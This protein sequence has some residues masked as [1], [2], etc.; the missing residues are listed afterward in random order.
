MHLQRLTR[1][2]CV[3]L[4]L[5]GV[6]SAAF[7]Q[8][9]TSPGI[10]PESPQSNSPPPSLGSVTR[11]NSQPLD[12]SAGQYWATYDLKPYTQNLPAQSAPE[13]AIVDW[14]IRE[15]GTDIWFHQPM[16]IMSAS[17][18]KLM[19]Y[20][21]EGVH[22]IVK[23]VYERFVNGNTDPQQFS[24]RLMMVGSSNWRT[25]TLAWMKSVDI[26]SP[27]VQG[28]LLSKEQAA[29]LAST[30]HNRSDFRELQMPQFVGMNGQMQTIDNQRSIAYVCGYDRIEQPYPSYV[31]ISDSISE[32][33]KIQL[34][35][36]VSVD[37]RMIDM[38]IHC[39]LNQIERL[40]SVSVDLPLANAQPQSMQVAIPQLIS[41]RFDERFQW[42]S[43][44]VLV[45]SCG[46]IAPPAES[47]Q[48]TL[49]NAQQSS[50]LFG[51]KK[52]IPQP[53]ASR[54]DALLVIQYNGHAASRAAATA[55]TNSGV[56]NTASANPI[57]HGRY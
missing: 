30:L 28:W 19:V 17:R 40:N 29:M 2:I 13:Q 37:E 33:Y 6:A 18:D 36:L 53:A 22:K 4:L 39:S 8:S 31:P 56:P 50:G 16:G 45:L 32:G 46:V 34:S 5:S 44:Q 3:L 38:Q 7:A 12:N 24:L 48:A 54:A 14:I 1:T 51:L 49:L 21:N 25:S 47:T 9:D 35:P 27:G 15:T 26:A 57:S 23:G 11:N 20:H 43:D 55:P 42:P 52:L 41:W 10:L